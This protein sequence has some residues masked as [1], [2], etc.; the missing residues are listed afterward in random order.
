MFRKQKE[1]ILESLT[2]DI[3]SYNVLYL[4]DYKGLNVEKMTQLRRS[5]REK[6][7]KI[8]VIKNTLL[9]LAQ[10]NAG[11]SAIGSEMLTG[12]SAVILSKDDPVSPA[13]IIKEFLKKNEMPQ[14]KAIVIDDTLYEAEKFK[15]FAAL[16]G[17]DE[18][19]AKVVGALN[20]P[21]SGIVFILSGLLR[22]FVNQID[23]LAKKKEEREKIL[24]TEW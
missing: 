13:K 5:L 23:Q 1:I 2:E 10:K 16:P 12:S 6:D 21:I 19:R 11:T 24:I 4:V 7:A 8:R 15:E 3:K 22:G 9:Q 17:V 14:I 20:S 18:L